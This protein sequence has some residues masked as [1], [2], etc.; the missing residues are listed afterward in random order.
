MPRSLETIESDLQISIQEAK[1]NL[2][3]AQEEYNLQ[4]V[5]ANEE[6][7]MLNA[8]DTAKSFEVLAALQKR[9]AKQLA[10]MGGVDGVLNNLEE[11]IVHEL[12]DPRFATDPLYRQTQREDF[13]PGKERE[14]NNLN[15]RGCYKAALRAL[16]DNLTIFQNSELSEEEAKS[17]EIHFGS[18]FH[19][20]S[21]K[22]IGPQFQGE[23]IWKAR[24]M[25]AYHWLAA[26]DKDM[27]LTEESIRKEGSREK[28]IRFEQINL[29]NTLA[30]Y[31]RTH[32]DNVYGYT[33][34]LLDNPSCEAGAWGRLFKEGPFYN[35]L[36]KLHKNKTDSKKAEYLELD[37]LSF[38]RNINAHILRQLKALSPQ[39]KIELL[40]N[41]N[42]CYTLKTS[43]PKRVMGYDIEAFVRDLQQSFKE[44]SK[45]YWQ[46]FAN[47][48]PTISKMITRMLPRDEKYE[49]YMTAL[50][51]CSIVYEMGWEL[52]M[53]RIAKGLLSQ[54]VLYEPFERDVFETILRSP[55]QKANHD[56]LSHVEREKQRLEVIVTSL[57]NLRKKIESLSAHIHP[58]E[59]F[60]A[61]RVALQK[62]SIEFQQLVQEKNALIATIMKTGK[63]L[64]LSGLI[65]NSMLLQTTKEERAIAQIVQSFFSSEPIAPQV[66]VI[67][68]GEVLK[69]IALPTSTQTLMFENRYKHLN[70]NWNV[71]VAG[72][73]TPQ[74]VFDEALKVFV[75]KPAFLQMNEAQIDWLKVQKGLPVSKSHIP[76]AF[77]PPA[78]KARNTPLSSV[79]TNIDQLIATESATIEAHFHSLSR[80]APQR[81]PELNLSEEER[82]YLYQ[83]ERFYTSWDLTWGERNFNLIEEKAYEAV[84]EI[85]GEE[86]A[87][88][89]TQDTFLRGKQKLWLLSAEDLLDYLDQTKL[90]LG[91]QFLNL[92]ADNDSIAAKNT[93]RQ[94]EILNFIKEQEKRVLKAKAAFLSSFSSSQRQEFANNYLDEL[95]KAADLGSELSKLMLIKLCINPEQALGLQI[96]DD[97]TV[98][99]LLSKN[100]Q[101]FYSKTNEHLD[102]L[103]N[104]LIQITHSQDPNIRAEAQRL[105]QDLSQRIYGQI[106]DTKR[107]YNAE[108]AKKV[109]SPNLLSNAARLGHP[110]AQIEIISLLAKEQNYDINSPNY[111][112]Y[113]AV[114]D[115]DAPPPI[116]TLFF[117][118]QTLIQQLAMQEEKEEAAPYF[119]IIKEKHVDYLRHQII[120]HLHLAE[121]S[122]ETGNN[123]G[124]LAQIRKVKE[125]IA[126]LKRQGT[127]LDYPFLIQHLNT[128]KEALSN[129]A[130][131]PKWFVEMSAK[132]EDDEQTIRLTTG[133]IQYQIQKQRNEHIVEKAKIFL[134]SNRKFD[135]L[136][137]AIDEYS[138]CETTYYELLNQ[139]NIPKQLLRSLLDLLVLKKNH[140]EQEINEIIRAFKS[141]MAADNLNIPDNE[142][143]ESLFKESESLTHQNRPLENLHS[144]QKIIEANEHVKRCDFILETHNKNTNIL[145]ET[146]DT[147]T[148]ILSDFR[149]EI[150]MA[151]NQV[152]QSVE[153]GK[154]SKAA[155]QFNI[156][157]KAE[158]ALNALQRETQSTDEK[159][160]KYYLFVAE[161]ITRISATLNRD[162]HDAGTLDLASLA[163]NKVNTNINSVL[164]NVHLQHQFR[165]N[166][167][168][169]K[170]QRLELSEKSSPASEILRER[171]STDLG[172]HV[173]LMF[174]HK[175]KS[176]PVLSYTPHQLVLARKYINTHLNVKDLYISKTG[177]EGNRLKDY[178]TEVQNHLN[179][180]VY[181]E[182]KQATREP[183]SITF[184]SLDGS[185][186]LTVEVTKYTFDQYIEKEKSHEPES[187]SRSKRQ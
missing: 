56:L 82:N 3:A 158:Q 84:Q 166:S 6:S 103:T 182:I 61:Q 187:S 160:M 75:G 59:D 47:A 62:F 18:V 55:H 176:E 163:M 23:K 64:A 29:I 186:A 125:I 131:N 77:V 157:K 153:P 140:L 19:Q 177:F 107:F 50:H 46:E 156:L 169:T 136:E 146:K 76:E 60:T 42:A 13:L 95:T 145:S 57:T 108:I 133:A 51:S 16:K 175:K 36:T 58:K 24:E 113:K 118:A 100:A 184:R 132:L 111:K 93:L 70:E 126:T 83:I 117:Q 30:S 154:P 5:A 52:E 22:T 69:P 134:K 10:K 54:Q 141:T 138:A 110:L 120:H 101:Q 96:S 139:E 123:E 112:A 8:S 39:Q 143:I 116:Q 41:Y 102:V 104:T 33:N 45:T 48:D 9:Y 86:I 27:L 25:L 124:A 44:N 90:E 119:Q 12:R 130:I 147:V 168:L 71:E 94:Q 37:P 178:L 109:L 183:I 80:S 172:N 106:R 105:K 4:E 149:A 115:G 11:Y 7:A 129:L 137:R 21:K 122:K 148:Q 128:F 151:K 165:I 155:N 159:G 65:N 150:R 161:N 152:A 179:S 66:E 31:Q 85:Y 114:F 98:H 92:A 79:F 28:C 74:K 162:L 15:E 2:L 73:K 43:D 78:Q 89:L 174:S 144:Y 49:R 35:E 164:R 99:E 40:N 181:A 34:R 135:A 26:S 67:D 81:E 91:I 171:A 72:E 87:S 38:M 97:T 32:N 88:R 121:K 142:F 14:T 17:Q 170:H 185:R 63:K 68:Q 167:A 180:G 127:E 53:A 20:G 173:K 1:E